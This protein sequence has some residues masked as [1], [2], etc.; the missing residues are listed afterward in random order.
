[1]SYNVVI[2]EK[3]IKQLI[4]IPNNIASKIISKIDGLIENPHPADS[5]KLKIIDAYRIRV[6]D[7]R[8]IYTI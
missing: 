7:Y 5:K 6:G 2:T 4:E 8:V 1:M 3:A